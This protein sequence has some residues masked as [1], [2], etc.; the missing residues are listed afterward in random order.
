ML[1]I[2]GFHTLKGYNSK[3]IHDREVL[4]FLRMAVKIKANPCIFLQCTDLNNMNLKSTNLPVQKVPS[5]H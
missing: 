3:S 1:T 4:F 2:S 5:R